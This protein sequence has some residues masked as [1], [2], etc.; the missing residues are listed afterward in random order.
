MLFGASY[1]H[2]YQPYRRLQEDLGLMVR[3][4]FTVVR[5]GESTWASYEPSEGVISFEALTEVVDAAH[6]VGL[7]VIMGTPSYAIPPW[8]ARRHPEIMITLPDGR[9]VQYGGRQ[10]I[11]YSHPTYRYYVGR[12]I[13][14]M[15]DHFG[16]HPAV[17][18]WQLDNEIG[19]HSIANDQVLSRFRRYVDERLGGVEGANAKWGLTYW[20]HKLSSIDDLWSPGGNTN[21][22]YALEWSRFGDDLATDFL[23]WQYDLVKPR[24][25]E[26]QFVLHDIVGGHGNPNSDPHALAEAMDKAAVN[27]YVPLQ[28]A[29]VLPE[30]DL[31]EMV[32]AAPF[33][34]KDMGTWPPLW[35]SD[36]GW[37][38]RGPRGS[39]FSVTEAQAGSIGGPSTNLPPY[40]GQL[41]LMAHLFLSRGADLV[42][43][44]HWHSLHYGFETYWGGVLGHDLEPN[45]LYAEATDLGHELLTLT[46]PTKDL[47]PDSDVVLLYSRDS[48]KAL[49]EMPPFSID[50]T[51]DPD[52]DSYHTVISRWYAAATDERIQLR[53]AHHD[54]DWTG[55]TVLVVPAMYVATDAQLEQLVEHARTGVHVLITCRTGY[56][57][58]WAMVRPVRA[59]GPLREA[60]GCS[61]QEFSTL[62]R[63]VGLAAADPVDGLPELSLP[64]GAQATA[65]A[66]GLLLEGADPLAGYD[67]PFLGRFPA[68][69]TNAVGTGRMTWVGTVPDRAST[70][71]LL[72]WALAERGHST[73]SDRWTDLPPSVRLSSA[74]GAG[75]R[76]LWFLANHSFDPVT[77]TPPTPISPVDGGNAPAPSITL[78]GWDSRVLVEDRG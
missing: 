9:T 1:Y 45:R 50:G 47:V 12:V 31:S 72:R 18:G 57:D 11:D 66:D 17:I 26:Q 7:K 69:T 53:I 76:R 5:V 6:Q 75:G 24:V 28:Q 21:P 52:P 32:A 54:S 8:L 58:E 20:S 35:R 10:N 51:A 65:W 63:P 48:L 3:A 38:L 77:V 33:W 29:L 43:Y 56:V 14:A 42:T 64:A 70:A 71:A 40:P 23:R 13:T 49:Q 19:V 62:P 61:Y 68:V 4:G 78:D 22:G 15:A 44:W 55:T 41:R 16:H 67:D 37:S 36:M 60:V 2:E 30:P 74:L 25:A 39:T 34:A 27:I 59:P 73:W 46:E